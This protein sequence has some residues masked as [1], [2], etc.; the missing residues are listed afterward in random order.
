[1]LQDENI[2]FGR[3]VSSQVRKD[4]RVFYALMTSCAVRYDVIYHPSL[5]DSQYLNTS[6][7]VGG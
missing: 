3:F 6:S 1:M 2:F 5:I 4:G 7:Y